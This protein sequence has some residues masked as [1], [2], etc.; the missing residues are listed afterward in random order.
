MHVDTGVKR[1]N[2]VVTLIWTG[3]RLRESADTFLL[4]DLLSVIQ[5]Y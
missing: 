3:I 5:I 1:L 2:A 4:L